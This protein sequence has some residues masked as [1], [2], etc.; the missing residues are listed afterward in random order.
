MPFPSDEQIMKTSQGLVDQLQAI[1]GKHPGFRPGTSPTSPSPFIPPLTPLAH[2]KGTLLTGTFTPTP[3]AST[4]STAPHFTAP[5]T[6]ILARFSTSTGLPQIPDTVPDTLPHGLA[7]RFHLPPTPDGRRSHTD[8]ITHSTPTFPTRTGAEFLEMLQALAASGSET[9]KPT[10]IERFLGAH[11]AALRHVMSA[12]PAVESYASDVY[13]SVNAFRLIAED[14]RVTSVRYRFLPQSGVRTLSA[15][16]FVARSAEYLREELEARVPRE[17]VVFRLVA[18]VAAEGDET[19]DATVL[20]PEERE[21]VE[22][23]TVTLDTLLSAE[24]GLRE[25]KRDIF[26]PIPR[27]P[28]VEASADPL[29]EMRAAVYLISGKQRRAA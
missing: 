15:E 21:V 9:E 19:D 7:V 10:S 24:D 2:A 18:Q 3:L 5:S 22:L 28:G 1:F 26:D 12:K 4:L 25:E 16:E 23:G 27:V 29:L 11:P 8:I 20:W 14:G 17:P 6:P 13:F